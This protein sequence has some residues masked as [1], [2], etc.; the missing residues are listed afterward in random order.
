[1]D[2]CGGCTLWFDDPYLQAH[3]ACVYSQNSIAYTD[4]FAQQGSMDISVNYSITHSHAWA[5]GHMYA[6]LL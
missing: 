2:I 5:S 1:M 3:Q 6:V 4:I